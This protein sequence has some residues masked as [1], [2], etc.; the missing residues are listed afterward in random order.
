[1]CSRAV[2]FWRLTS[3][4]FLPPK[5][6]RMKERLSDIFRKGPSILKCGL[7]CCKSQL[8]SLLQVCSLRG[9]RSDNA[10]TQLCRV[11]IPGAVQSRGCGTGMWAVRDGLGLGIS[12]VFSNLNDPEVL[13]LAVLEGESFGWPVPS[14]EGVLQQ[15][16]MEAKPSQQLGR[17]RGSP[18]HLLSGRRCDAPHRGAGKA[19]VKGERHK[20]GLCQKALFVS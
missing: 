9:W 4:C 16:R 1:M 10:L 17:C 5:M 2:G 3:P 14:I 15:P 19:A 18:R 7:C 13:C 8:C 20:S 12:K 11:T 6:E